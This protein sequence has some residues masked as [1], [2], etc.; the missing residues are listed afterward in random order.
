MKNSFS[1]ILKAGVLNTLA[2]S[3]ITASFGKRPSKGKR[4]GFA[5]LYAF[6]ILYMSGL[7]ALFT[8]FLYD[9]LGGTELKS[10]IPCMFVVG[11]CVLNLVA[12]LFSSSGFL[13]KAKDLPLLFS[14]PVSKFRILTVK[15]LLFYMSE[16]LISLISIGVSMI[17]FMVLDGVTFYSLLAFFLGVFIAPLLPM[18]IGMTA[19]FG[20]GMLIRNLKHKNQIVTAFTVVISVGFVIAYYV[21]ATGSSVDEILLNATALIDKFSSVYFPARLFVSGFDGN[22]LSMLLFALINVV[23]MLLV[24]LIISP[25]YTTLVAAFN[26]SFKAS[27]Y[28]YSAGK[29]GG[30]GGAFGVLLGKEIKRVISSANYT[31]N[32]CMG[33]LML[34]IVAVMSF[35]FDSTVLTDDIVKAKEL[36]FLG[37]AAASVFGCGM[38]STTTSTISLEAKTLWILRS[39]PVN[40]ATV[41]RAK[42]L[43]NILIQLPLSTAALTVITLSMGFTFGEFLLLFALQAIVYAAAAY[44]G[45]LT[46]LLFPKLDWQNEIQVIKQSAAVGLF[47]LFA[48][49]VSTVSIGLG[50][51]G[52]FLVKLD[53]VTVVVGFISIY[54]FLLILFRSLALGWGIKKFDRI[55]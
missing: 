30:S 25:R 18:S 53:P 51:L 45:L 3:K 16:T 6:I 55:Y 34:A 27:G 22:A 37:V 17:T 29:A 32:S 49:V 28:K 52:Y 9:K 31:L 8:Y 15:M 7:S 35:K 23:P 33:V 24:L 54:S 50:A 48:F 36:I 11:S 2:N 12:S 41:F 21:L 39:A 26:S 4:I 42:A 19:A 38:A 43:T 13:F 44:A 20:I 1:V 5:V 46:N 10:L 47:M 14:L 40:M